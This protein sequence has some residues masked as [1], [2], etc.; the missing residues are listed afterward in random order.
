[1]PR[2]RT[3][4]ALFSKIMRI[5]SG[6]RRIFLRFFMICAQN[7]R[8]FRSIYEVSSKIPYN[9]TT[10]LLLCQQNFTLSVCPPKNAGNKKER[11]RKEG[12]SAKLK[13]FFKDTCLRKGGTEISNMSLKKNTI[14][15][16]NYTLR[17]S[18]SESRRQ[19]ARVR[20]PGKT[21]SF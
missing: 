9:Y 11:P 14:C 8:F 21:F 1:V 15:L 20:S 13:F 2:N 17:N 7:A 16:L 10:F 4:W 5:L 19:S 3:F 6:I 12:R 18:E